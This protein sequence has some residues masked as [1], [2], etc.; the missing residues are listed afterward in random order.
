MDRKDFSSVIAICENLLEQMQK[1]LTGRKNLTAVV[2]SVFLFFFLG[3]GYAFV[4]Q[5]PIHDAVPQMT[6]VS[7]MWQVQLG[8][9]LMPLYLKIRGVIP[10]PLIII[11]LSVLYLSISVYILLH[12]IGV[13][14]KQEIFLIS[15]FLSVNLFTLEISAVHQYFADVFLVALLFSCL[16][17]YFVF[18]KINLSRSILSAVCLF[19]S[20]G[21]YPA[22]ITFA[23]C[24]FVLV[25][26]REILT[27]WDPE[28]KMMVRILAWTAIL[29]VS[30]LAYIIANRLALHFMESTASDAPWSI[31]TVGRMS[32]REIINSI[33]SNYRQFFKTFLDP[34]SVFG[35]DYFASS[36]L[37]L[38]FSIWLT[39][40]HQ[41]P[42]KTFL[43]ILLVSL[44]PLGSRLVNI[45]TESVLAYRT[46]YAQFL[47]YPILIWLFFVGIQNTV[48]LS[49]KLKKGLPIVVLLLSAV[50]IWDNVKFNNTGF[51][52]QKIMYDRAEYHVGQVIADYW[53]YQSENEEFADCPVAIIGCFSFD[54]SKNPVFENYRIVEGMDNDTGVTY[55][56]IVESYAA[57]SGCFLNWDPSDSNAVRNLQEVID[58]PCYPEKGYISEVDG[59]LV[60]KLSSE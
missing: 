30:G 53:N 4:N 22:F 18:E 16:G 15:G 12:A 23:V 34:H 58:M 60:L 10:A 46:M 26:L 17:V 28:T 8:R 56:M 6:S 27:K 38:A 7:Y 2:A 39:A 24:L 13:E 44:F 35:T 37:L 51:V 20:F 19:L 21:I 54:N 59:Y 3:N 57:L 36:V 5:Y 40:R 25:I 41:K 33:S 1:P 9:F 55:E 32:I 52:W 29:L 11:S 43:V 48:D 42:G 49:S 47:F 14:T 45:M 50:I 31:F